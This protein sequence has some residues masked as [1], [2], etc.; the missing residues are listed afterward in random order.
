MDGPGK[1]SARERHWHIEPQRSCDWSRPHGQPCGHGV[2]PVPSE[3]PRCSVRRYVGRRHIIYGLKVVDWWNGFAG[4]L[5]DEDGLPLF[6]LLADMAEVQRVGEAA[7]EHV[8]E[9]RLN[10]WHDDVQH[11]SHR[12]SGVYPA[13][14]VM[15][16]NLLD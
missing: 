9:V 13:V 7:V 14:P 4:T 11:D 1:G 5:P 8:C 15:R 6:G 10:C 16:C 2:Y 12:P 3:L